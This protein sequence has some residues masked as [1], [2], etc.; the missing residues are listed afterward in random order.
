MIRVY[1]GDGDARRAVAATV[2]KSVPGDLFSSRS[3]GLADGY[4]AM[5][6]A[7]APA[8]CQS[9]IREIF[10]GVCLSSAPFCSHI[11]SRETGE[12]AFC[13]LPHGR[14]SHGPVCG[15]SQ[16]KEPARGFTLPDTVFPGYRHDC[17]PYLEAGGG[18][19]AY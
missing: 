15:E 18:V 10:G 4:Q 9:Y 19:P 2:K 12:G 14:S 11:E 6:G 17:P 8:R 1:T 5:V 16:K 13:P 7:K 3:I